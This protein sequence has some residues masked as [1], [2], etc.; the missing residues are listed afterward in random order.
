MLRRLIGL[1]SYN[2]SSFAPRSLASFL[3]RHAPSLPLLCF[4][5]TPALS[6]CDLTSF[7]SPSRTMSDNKNLE[8]KIVSHSSPDSAAAQCR[9]GGSE[10][11]RSIDGTEH[12]RG[13]RG[14]ERGRSLGMEK[15]EASFV[16]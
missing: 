8:Y 5:S 7:F 13:G 15:E 16:R 14:E 3:A 10:R 2:C 4:F 6:K 11:H 9:S 1:V 12:A